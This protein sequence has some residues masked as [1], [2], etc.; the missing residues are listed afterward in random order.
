MAPS[1]AVHSTIARSEELHVDGPYC[2][3]KNTTTSHVY[4]A[5][6]R[7]HEPVETSKSQEYFVD[8]KEVRDSSSSHE[9]SGT[10][11][12]QLVSWTPSLLRIGPL[13]GLLALSFAF[14]QI[15]ASYAVLATSHGAEVIH[16]K[17]QPTVYLAV[18]TAISNKALAFAVVQGTV[19]TLWLNLVK[20]T[21]LGQVHR[22]WTYGLHVVSIASNLLMRALP[23]LPN[24]TKTSSTKQCWLVVTSTHWLSRAFAPH[25]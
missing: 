16:W 9:R 10:D 21:T 18:L 3:D 25:S 5:P 7:S 11:E 6:S 14:A 15:F 19:I 12:P 20:G 2:H 23:F 22:D 8:T 24:T 13:C 4:N 1:A 17:Y